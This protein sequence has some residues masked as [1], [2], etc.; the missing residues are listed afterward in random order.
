MKELSY[1]IEKCDVIEQRK[2]LDQAVKIALELV[3]HHCDEADVVILQTSGLS[4]KTSFGTIEN[5]VF[6]RD[7]QLCLRI[8]NKNHAG[9]VS[10]TDISVAAIKNAV[11]KALNIVRYTSMDPYS[12]IADRD[13]LA[14]KIQD[15]DLYHPTEIDT[16]YAVKLASQAEKT[17]LKFDPRI[18]NTEGGFFDSRVSVKVVGNSYG[19]C[20]GYC[21]TM[22][23]LA[24]GVVAKDNKSMERGAAYTSSRAIEDLQLPEYI[25]EKC[26][27]R[28]LSRLSPRKIPTMT[29]PVMFSAEVAVDLF[30]ALAMAINGACV[31]RK[32]TFLLHS[33]GKQIL[34]KWLS[35]EE[36]PHLLK[37]IGSAPFDSEGVETQRR[38]IIKDGILQS[39]LLTSYSARRLGLQ[40]TG[41]AGGIYN[42]LI[43]SHT[44]DFNDM[45]QQ[46]GRGLFLTDLMGYSVNEMTGDYS[47]GASGFWV[48]NGVVQYPVHDITIAGNLKDMWRNIVSI[49]NDLEKHSRIQCGSVLLSSMKIGG[50]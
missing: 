25:G 18:I 4:V 46:M 32:Y 12:G 20:Q 1:V 24:S 9:C 23:S 6:N 17:A 35:I 41:H 14:W 28:A 21:A 38:K 27:R 22:Y 44:L 13:I 50:E 43:V 26:A 45:L 40:S 8:L 30:H 37:G 3:E 31:Y 42:W 5:I 39:W 48:D 2:S 36:H 11:Q 47:R 19:M 34:P 49:G 16:E 29:V 33:L 15:L 7:V 10:S